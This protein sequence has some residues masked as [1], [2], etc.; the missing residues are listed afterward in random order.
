MLA[1]VPLALPTF[2]QADDLDDLCWTQKFTRTDSWTPQPKWLSHPS[3]TATVTSN[4]TAICFAVDEPGRG[5][6][7][8]AP[9]A[10][11]SLMEQPYLVLRYRGENLNTASTDYLLNLDDQDNRHQ[12]HALRLCD[13]QADGQ[14]HTTAV[15]ISTLTN[16]DAIGAMAIQVQANRQGRGRLWL[17]WLSFRGDP[18]A[19][20]TVVQPVP[21]APRKPDWT[22]PLATMQWSPR[23]TWLGN[24]ADDGTFR[25]EKV[26]GTALFHV[27]EPNRGMKWSA[28]LPEPLSLEGHRYLSIRYR[29][30]Q[31]SRQ[32]DYTLCGQGKPRLGGPG[33]LS[34]VSCVEL[35]DDGRWHTLD[36][37]IRRVA[38]RLSPITS[39]AMQVQAA[40]PEALLDV[41]D[42]RLVNSRRSSHLADALNWR[43][44]ATWQGFR[45]VP[46]DT[47]AT[48]RSDR[49]LSYL[50]LAD[51]FVGNGSDA[52]RTGGRPSVTVDGV[53]FELLA[54]MPDLA[55]TAVRGKSELRLSVSRMASEVYLLLLAAMTGAEEPAYG[56]GPLREIEDVDRFRLRLEYA[57]GTVD[58]CLPMNVATGRFGVVSGPQALVAPADPTRHLEAVVLCDRT[59]QA[60]FGVAAITVCTEGTPR[61]PEATEITP[62]LRVKPSGQS[63]YRDVLEATLAAGGPPTI[64]QLVHR[65]SGWQ[66]LPRPCPL[67]ELRVD[68]KSIPASDLEPVPATKE[69]PR[70]RWY[71]VRS[72]EGLRLGLD[73]KADG[74]DSLR[75]TA[76]LKNGS[77]QDHRTAVQVPSLSYRLAERSDDAYY[78]VPRRGAVMD[79]RDCSYHER[80][81]GTFPVQFLD[82]FSPAWGRGLSL[83][84]EDTLCVRK[85]YLLKKQAGVFTLAVEYPEQT[86]RPGE[87]FQTPPAMLTAT[88]G[89]WHRGLESYRRWLSRWYRPQAPRQP[90]FREVFNFRQRFL[91]GND[92]LYDARQGKLHLDRAITEAREEFGGIDYLHLFDWG[93]CGR[94]GR[95]YGRTGDY[96]PYDYLQG[97]RKA[98]R[99]AI[100]AVQSQGVPVGLY[101]E[102]YLLEEHGKLGQQ[103]GRRWQ[104][105]GAD[106]KGKYWPQSSEMVMCAGVSAWQ[107][108]QASTYATKVRELG[109][110]GMYLDEF[111][112]AG[113]NQD[114]WSN[115]HGHKAPSYAVAAERDCTRVVRQRIDGVKR[116][117]ALYGE[118]SPVD[119]TSQYQ[120][121]SFT[122]AMST[123]R[124]TTTLVPL[125]LT[126]FALPDF[127]TIEILY[128]DKPT[129]SWATGVKWV[130][131]NGEA[132]WLEGPATEWFEPET[133]EA[134][135]HCYAILHKHRDAFTTLEPVPLVPTEQGGVYANAFATEGKTAYT[136]YNARRVTAR[137]PVLRLPH[138]DGVTFED[139]WHH[140]PARVERAGSEDIIW[141]VLGPCDVGCLVARNV[142]GK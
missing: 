32:G 141:L 102:G 82:T 107:E 55:V 58:E 29:A 48:G 109:V 118:E 47:V 99:E 133:R 23:N 87:Q 70:I 54:R 56:S 90:W 35:I 80:Y 4:G 77:G 93:Y 103:F 39:M 20:A 11:V 88:D 49:W 94:Y 117:V 13:V 81:C 10:A 18:P 89:D 53:P 91:W 113:V 100:A 137:G 52:Q 62:P 72:V 27:D 84:T 31:L 14:W 43:P 127:K 98:V 142:D 131:F 135:R 119:V 136:F 66:Y 73:V 139:E 60:G 64:T 38:K 36:V 41:S 57:D 132:I 74:G 28:D 124:K 95:I 125:N 138:R 114:C 46:I 120:D 22:A 121:G 65:P 59:R 85:H 2:T 33:Y 108:V 96:S 25:V 50:R 42:I 40:G 9:L 71:R 15:D 44:G 30:R 122:Y 5:M 19:D 17:Q 101:I 123:A 140:R 106:G 105:I 97:G 126:R 26:A 68:G 129:G 6:K 24:P 111:G 116:N 110:D 130:F 51:W 1:I 128:C 83:R 112:F 8:S 3:S 76:Q 12:L 86:L 115:E 16:A 69:E 79:H 45:S 61:H 92:P 7:W 134:I 34:L 37:D 63:P 75:V 78:L 104:T 21:A 67:V